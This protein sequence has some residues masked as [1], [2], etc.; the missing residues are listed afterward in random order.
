LHHW[1]DVCS[2]YFIDIFDSGGPQLKWVEIIEVRT[3]SSDTGQVASELKKIGKELALSAKKTKLRLYRH[4]YIETDFSIHLLHDSRYTSANESPLGH[5][6]AS[7]LAEL[8]IIHRS[9]WVGMIEQC[10]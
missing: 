5:H 10:L 8:G 9:V 1:H 6:L 3:S 4:A 7:A 2:Y